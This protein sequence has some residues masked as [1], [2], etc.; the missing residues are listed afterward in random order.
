MYLCMSEARVCMCEC[1]CVCVCVCVHNCQVILY[2]QF[3]DEKICAGKSPFR[4]VFAVKQSWMCMCME[5][6]YGSYMA[7]IIVPH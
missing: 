3:K 4:F 1:V 2:C 6:I 7:L 5:N